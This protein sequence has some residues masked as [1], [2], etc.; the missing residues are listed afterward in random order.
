[1]QVA[2]S[3]RRFLSAEFDAQA[4]LLL[5]DAN[6]HLQLAQPG[7]RRQRTPLDR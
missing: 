5:T 2:E 4:L 3:L 6:D 7:N 1:M